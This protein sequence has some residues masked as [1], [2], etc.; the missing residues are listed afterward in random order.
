MEKKEAPNIQT[1]RL[2]LRPRAE[3]DIPNMLKNV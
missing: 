2:I 3:K 1:E